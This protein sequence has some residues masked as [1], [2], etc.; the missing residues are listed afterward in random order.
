MAI[1]RLD[2]VYKNLDQ[3][4][5]RHLGGLAKMSY[6]GVVAVIMCRSRCLEQLH[7]IIFRLLQDVLAFTGSPGIPLCTK[8][9]I[10]R[11]GAPYTDCARCESWASAVGCFRMFARFPDTDSVSNVVLYSL[12]GATY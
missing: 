2:N 9:S 5:R 11:D 6:R 10:P 7:E 4:F 3:V 1:S 12:S 8:P